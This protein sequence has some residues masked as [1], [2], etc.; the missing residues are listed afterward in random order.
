MSSYSEI[1]EKAVTRANESEL[2][3]EKFREEYVRDAKN[4]LCSAINQLNTYGQTKYVEVSRLTLEDRQ[5][6]VQELSEHPNLQ[7]HVGVGKEP[8][9]YIYLKLVQQ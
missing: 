1:I 5:K 2:D 9:V 4:L 7:V 8:K 3:K 6:L